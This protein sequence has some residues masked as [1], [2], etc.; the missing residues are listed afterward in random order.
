MFVAPVEMMIGEQ[1]D[2][3]SQG[4]HAQELRAV[5]QLAGRSV[6]RWR[7]A[8][9]GQRDSSTPSEFGGSVAG[10]GVI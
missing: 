7:D 5:G 2:S 10:V 8:G 4:P 3:H 6:N 9:A 1:L